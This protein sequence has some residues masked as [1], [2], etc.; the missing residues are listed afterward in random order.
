MTDN[1]LGEFIDQRFNRGR[2]TR[3]GGELEVR[4]KKNQGLGRTPA[5][6]RNPC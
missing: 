1:E 4:I 3:L 6:Q 5:A 2:V